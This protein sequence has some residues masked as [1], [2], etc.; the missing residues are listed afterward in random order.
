MDIDPSIVKQA[1]PGV[2][3]SLGALFFIR[4]AWHQ[5]LGAVFVGATLSWYAAPHVARAVGMPEGLAGFLLGLCG[6]ALI[7]KAFST[8]ETLDLGTL[9]RRVIEKFTGLR[10]DA[11]E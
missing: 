11:K 8:W 9:L 7:A 6:M 5:R 4:G 10:S 3:G 1:T 2:V